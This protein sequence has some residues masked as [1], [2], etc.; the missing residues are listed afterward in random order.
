[1][2]P[3]KRKAQLAVARNIKAKNA[4]NETQLTIINSDDDNKLSDYHDSDDNWH[5]NK[6]KDSLN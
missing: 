3:K 5:D 2:P 4:I 1:M 6:L